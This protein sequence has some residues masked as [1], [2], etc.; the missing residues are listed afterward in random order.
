MNIFSEN[1]QNKTLVTLMNPW[2]KREFAELYLSRFNKLPL[3]NCVHAIVNQLIENCDHIKNKL[4]DVEMITQRINSW[5]R[6]KFNCESGV[7]KISYS[8]VCDH[9]GD[10]DDQS[11]ERFCEYEKCSETDK[12]GMQS[13]AQCFNKQCI[14]E[15]SLCNNYK[16][17]IDGSDEGDFCSLKVP[18]QGSLWDASDF[19]VGDLTLHS[20]AIFV[21]KMNY[22]FFKVYNFHQTGSCQKKDLFRCPGSACLPIYL[23]C[24]GVCI[25]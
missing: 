13:E 8:L 23:R 5:N 6:P 2:L 17:C 19:P 18:C 12:T 9:H 3:M 25:S 21:Y 20:D 1:M 16:D 4:D 10:C 22:N 14:G 11:D 7:K 15:Y 24:N